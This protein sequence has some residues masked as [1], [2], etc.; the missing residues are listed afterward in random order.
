METSLANLQLD[1]KSHMENQGTKARR[2]ATVQTWGEPLWN[3]MP[4][5]DT[6]ESLADLGKTSTL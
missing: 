3:F 1:R 4:T 6:G 5:T 2:T